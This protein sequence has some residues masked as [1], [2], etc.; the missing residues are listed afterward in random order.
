M[1]RILYA[2]LL[3]SAFSS[4]AG[5][6]PFRIR[7][8]AEDYVVVTNS[9]DPKTC[10]TYSPG[11]VRLPGGRLIATMD[12]G[13]RQPG[14]G[15][16]EGKGDAFL[17]DDHGR[18]WRH[19]LSFPFMHARPFLAGGGLYV[20]GHDV[21]SNFKYGDLCIVRSD[22]NGETWSP[23]SRLTEGQSWHQ[24]ACNVWY[25][26]GCVY[27]VQ[28]RRMSGIIWCE[29]LAPVLMRGK[30]G[31]DLLKRENWTFA[32]E[33]TFDSIFN[34]DT[35]YPGLDYTGIPYGRFQK[36]WPTPMGWLE[37][38][39]V[40]VR[41]PSHAWF[42]K[43]GKTFYLFMRSHIPGNS[44]YACMAQVRENA[45]GSM[46]TGLVTAPSGKKM[47]YLPFPGGYMRFHI[48][49]DE[50]T[51]LYWLLGS[52][53]VDSLM[54]KNRVGDRTRLVLHFS[55]NL[56]DWCFAGFVC[57]GKAPNQSR[58]YASMVID[59]DNLDILSR[60]GD[61]NACNAHDGDMITFHVVRDFRSLVY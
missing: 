21:D 16:H 45:D 36:K 41:D 30:E 13:F 55:R 46:T 23:V 6:N 49:Y 59:G 53:T 40:Q 19:I 26:N 14:K 60:S 28:E 56:V 3:M 32:S 10:F 4:L 37:T 2:S 8:L 5:E 61:E 54:G 57:A 17:S 44:G 12:W 39:V 47:L 7:P 33:M 15:T 29:K 1:K 48:L 52:Q 24:S 50:Q 42:D 35:S 9:S 31:A 18:T 38:N 11:L 25:A 27:L 43:T 58:H 34:G 20:M 22:D 51:S